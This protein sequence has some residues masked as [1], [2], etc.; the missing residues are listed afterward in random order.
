MK[1]IHFLNWEKW[2]LLANGCLGA[3]YLAL[4]YIFRVSS[5]DIEAGIL[6][7]LV[8]LSISSCIVVLLA[9]RRNKMAEIGSD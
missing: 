4:K 1:I 6:N 3:S 9:I 5:T 7:T 2:L 8:L